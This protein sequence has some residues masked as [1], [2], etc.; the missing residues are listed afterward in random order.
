MHRPPGNAIPQLDT[1][2]FFNGT[3]AEAMRF[4]ERTLGGKIE[5]MM[6]HTQA[7]MTAEMPPGMAERIMHARLSLGD[8]ILMGSDTM[9]GQPDA[10]MH[11]FS[12]SLIYPTVAEANKVFAA[13]G[14]GGKV[15]MPMQKTFWV[16]AFGMLTDR[17]GTGWMVN[18]GAAGA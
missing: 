5:M 3:C 15:T 4:Y 7:P 11:G 18:G 12:L 13:L 1:Y 6:T 10:G 14:E 16:E 9:L 2:L 17:F 8:R